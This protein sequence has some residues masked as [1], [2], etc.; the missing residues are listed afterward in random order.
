MITF[1]AF[2]SLTPKQQSDMMCYEGVYLCSRQEPEF[3]IDL[4]QIEHFYI[5]A[6]YHRKTKSLV[7][8]RS[9]T[10]TDQLHAYF[11]NSSLL[12]LE[13]VTEIDSD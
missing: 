3:V 7:S 6:F 5:E 1:A 12:F 11:V 13:S 10:S 2:N 9:F 8:L 4:Y